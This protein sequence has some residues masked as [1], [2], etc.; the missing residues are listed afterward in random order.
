MH[1]KL[2]GFA[3]ILLSL[4]LA[5]VM[6]S[7]VQVY[8][9]T[10]GFVSGEF[11][12]GVEPIED[13][14][15]HVP[16]L[17]SS[18]WVGFSF[19]LS[20]NHNGYK[21]YGVLLPWNESERPNVVMRVVNDTGVSLLQ[22]DGYSNTAWNATKVYTAAI[23]NDSIRYF[24]FDLR[25]LDMASKYDAVF[26]GLV[27]GTKPSIVMIS[28]RES[29]LQGAP[30]LPNQPLNMGVFGVLAVAG[31]FFILYDLW[32]GRSRSKTRNQKRRLSR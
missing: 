13:I 29:W 16:P 8:Q 6:L 18:E 31:T 9:Q 5:A 12:T 24:E 21:A 30:A 28:I 14:P 22:F 15:I 19:N 11:A 25:D 10:E 2:A 20:E 23:L 1:L 17:N 32:N 27:D 7:G 26:R 3:L 4:V